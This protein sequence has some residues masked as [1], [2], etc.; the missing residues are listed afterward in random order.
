M[1]CKTI[2]KP[3]ILLFMAMTAFTLA[4]CET[5]GGVNSNMEKIQGTYTMTSALQ[6]GSDILEFIPEALLPSVKTASVYELDGKWYFKCNIVNID[7]SGKFAS[8]GI[9]NEVTWN[10]AIGEYCFKQLD[11]EEWFNGIQ[12]S[13]DGFMVD[14]N[15]IL[16]TKSTVI[17]WRK[18]R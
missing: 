5:V 16:F 18:V 1:I 11:D 7:Q 14:D 8:H 12:K 2:L 9:I 6:E 3:I 15:G 17:R 4:G 10:G 13:L